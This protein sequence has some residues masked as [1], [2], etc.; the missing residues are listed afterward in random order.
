QPQDD[1]SANIVCDS[2]S[3]ANAETGAGSDKTNSGGEKQVDL[4]EKTAEF[5]QDPWIRPW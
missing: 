2:P 5:D 1:T 4:E 3:P